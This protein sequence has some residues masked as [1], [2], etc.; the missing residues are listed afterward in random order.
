MRAR[1]EA[2]EWRRGNSGRVEVTPASNLGCGEG[3]SGAPRPTQGSVRDVGCLGPKRKHEAGLNRPD[4][5][6]AWRTG[7]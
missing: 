1:L 5:E 4:T 3:R 2:G 7:A 6:R